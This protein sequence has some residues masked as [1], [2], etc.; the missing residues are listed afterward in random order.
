MPGG[1]LGG[2]FLVHIVDAHEFDRASSS[3]FGVN[4]GV[5]LAKRAGADDRDAEF[6][7]GWGFDNRSSHA[8]SVPLTR[9]TDNEQLG[10]NQRLA[11]ANFPL[12]A[13]A[14][15]SL[16]RDVDL[17][18]FIVAALGAYIL[19]SLPSGYLVARAK[20]IDI[21]SVGSGNIGATNVFRTLGRRLGMLVLVLDGIKGYAACVWLC[22]LL[23]PAFAG[24]DY[25]NLEIRVTAGVAAILGHNYTCW[26]RFKGGKGIATSAGVLAALVPVSLI[27][28][29]GIWVVTVVATRYVS[30]ASIAGSMAL[31][32]AALATHENQGSFLM[33]LV[34]TAMTTL[35]VYKHRSNIRRLINGTESRIQLK[36]KEKPT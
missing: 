29:A 12:P 17:K 25:W 19:G 6:R 1:V 36:R 35:A 28:I 4:A 31:P 18:P 10:A 15:A 2:G 20:G 33:F 32:V 3:E 14:R 26:L 16:N 9:G 23:I 7:L 34:L 21:R 5:L 8:A 13:G 11:F 30:L 22:D 27:I 24:A